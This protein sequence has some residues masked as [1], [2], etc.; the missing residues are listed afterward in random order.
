MTDD[1]V[2][3]ARPALCWLDAFPWIEAAAS[4]TGVEGDRAPSWWLE[5]VDA[6][7][8]SMRAERLADLSDLA[9]EHLT[10]WTIGQIFPGLPADTILSC[11]S[12]SNRARN[13]LARF[14]YQIAG[15]LQGLELGELFDMPN[16]GIG[17]VDSMIQALA[18]AS[19][20]DAA[21]VLLGARNE[22]AGHQRAD[23]DEDDRLAS[24]GE[25]FLQ[26]LRLIGNWYVALGI[27]GQ[28]L[29]GGTLPPGTPP[30]VVMARQR[31]ELI[32]AVDVLDKRQTELDA[33]EL[34]QR[35]ISALDRRAQQILALRLFADQPET[36]DE[37]GQSLDVSRERVRQIEA[38]VR[39]EMVGFLDADGML[40]MV[41]AAVREIVGTVMP[42]ADLIIMMPALARTVEAVGQPA[43]RVLDR[44]DCAYEIED[45]WCASP[46]ILSAQTETLTRL[47]EL[48]N[49][50]GVVR[51]G[52]LGALNANQ[53]DA[54]GIA[55]LPDWLTY[56]GYVLDGDYVFTRTQTVGDR[57]ASILS[58]VGSPMASQNI[59]D[60]F[61]VERSLS[62][63]KNA[64]ASD[65]RFERVDR[66]RWA[67]AEW[68][69]DSY[70]GVRAL[71]REEVARSGGQVTMDTLVERITGKYSV[72]AS[73]VV[74]YASAPPFEARG[75]IVGFA[76]D[77]RDARKSPE[78][79]RRLYRQAD[80]WFY[81]V[82]ITK[83]HLRGS[84]SVAPMAI[85]SILDL[86]YGQSRLL[87][88]VLG[89]QSV[90]WTSNQPSFGT[91]RR[92]LVADDVEIGSEIFLVI[93]DDGS[94]RVEPVDVSD[95]DPLERAL[96]LVGTTGTG[97]RKQPR[98]ALA[99]AIGLPA[100]SP[101]ASVIGGYRERGDSDIAE[102]LLPVRDEL[103][104]G[105][106]ARPA[107]P[108]AD[109]DEI[110]DLL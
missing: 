56:S 104:V 89:P 28:P 64:L 72:T 87:Q 61:A 99:T 108:S 92:F 18:D 62:S 47:Q 60:R 107:T 10:R 103:D 48:A 69:L 59:L 53:S 66:D 9:L 83:D 34:L 57:A 27:P 40:G 35:C 20:M 49:R 46:T 16:V 17:T 5:P 12:M 23:H 86:Q 26:D 88:S 67:L 29:F 63:L 11:L 91:I 58:I 71:V 31:V 109:I 55:W 68:G 45:G 97:T 82:K 38:S 4:D 51:I 65:D 22:G 96:R 1:L 44:L 80:S 37:L 54:A 15:D 100:D 110:M 77:D 24:L 2:I 21:P 30:E 52:D 33:P 43:W 73:S 8:T 75:G 94:F 79:T 93:G 95:G 14:G 3:D 19:T 84:G 13:A 90:S 36:L 85:A 98:V 105:V 81:R 76:H 39:A 7:A 6:P 106:A 102:L 50:H 42:L 101:A 78:R 74:A 70:L 32:S 41:G 25:S